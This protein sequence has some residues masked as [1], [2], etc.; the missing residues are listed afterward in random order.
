MVHTLGTFLPS[1]VSQP[2]GKD[3]T[4]AVISTQLLFRVPQ[5]SHR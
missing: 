2:C 1:N 3:L 4:K 5:G